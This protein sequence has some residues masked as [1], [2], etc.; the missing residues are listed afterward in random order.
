MIMNF[1]KAQSEAKKLPPTISNDDLLELYALYKQATVGDI[2]TSCPSIFD[3][4]GRAKWNSWNN[5]KGLSQ[6]TC[7][8]RYCDLVEALKI[9]YK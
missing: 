1:E 8:T 6:E 4:R 3:P 5:K 2:N 7:K 9:K